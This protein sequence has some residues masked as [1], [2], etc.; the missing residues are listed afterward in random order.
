MVWIDAHDADPAAWGGRQKPPPPEPI[1]PTM[2]RAHDASPRLSYQ[3]A[4][5]L[6]P[7]ELADEFPD[8]G[9]RHAYFQFGLD[10]RFD[11]SIRLLSRGYVWDGDAPDQRF[12]V[13]YRRPASPT[14]TVPCD[15]YAVWTRYQYGRVTDVR[16]YDITFTGRK[17]PEDE[18]RLVAWSA[19]QE[20]IRIRLAELELARNPAFT[21]YRLEELDAWE[22]IDTAIRWRPHAFD[23]RQG[24]IG[25]L[26]ED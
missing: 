6:G 9:Y 5:S 21:R 2:E 24:P 15:K 11:S 1:P 20:P 4:V 7:E 22:D 26:D 19:L 18:K 17:D 13:L 25:V 16:R 23:E 10:L 14:R 12:R 8:A 3:D